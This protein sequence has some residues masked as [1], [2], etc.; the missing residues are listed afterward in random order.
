MPG[1][2]VVYLLFCLIVGGA[3]LSE[4]FV[5]Q[6]SKEW[7]EVLVMFVG[8]TFCGRKDD[9]QKKKKKGKSAKKYK[10]KDAEKTDKE[11]TSK[12]KKGALGKAK[13]AETKV[14]P[15]RSSV[16]GEN[17][18]EPIS[19]LKPGTQ[20]RQKKENQ[21]EKKKTRGRRPKAKRDKD[22]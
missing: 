8:R 13:K 15:K 18:V 22:V 9:R 7:T 1:H 17:K 11:E 12:A 10:D 6:Y 16:V 2:M 14:K 20:L 5:Y 19:L 21:V 4:H 3:F